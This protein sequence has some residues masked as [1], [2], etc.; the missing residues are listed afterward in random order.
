MSKKRK[1]ECQFCTSRKCYAQIYRDEEPKYDEVYCYK[2]AD[3]AAEAA[4]RVLGGRGS[5]IKR[6]HRSSSSPVS[7]G[8]R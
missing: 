4:D 7:R 1:N 3:E 6:C 8:E 5:G 2:H